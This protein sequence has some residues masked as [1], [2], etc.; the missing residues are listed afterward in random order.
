MRANCSAPIIPAVSGVTIGVHRHHV[1]LGEQV[2]ERVR[3]LV[4]VGVVRDHAHAE[5]LEP[6]A[7]SARPTAP[8]PDDARR[9]ARR[10]ATPGSAGRGWCRR[11]RSVPRARRRRRRA[12]PRFTAN[13]S[14]TVISATASALR[15]GARSTGMPLLGGGGRR[16]RWW[17]RPGTSRWRR[18]GRSSTGPFTESDST[19]RRSAPS[20]SMRAARSSALYMRSGCWSIHGSSTTSAS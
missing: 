15:P 13:R 17:G 20:A 8:R 4:V 19:T 10:A 1:G 14:A 7:S 16:R 18:S 5:A 2:V 12:S 3:G 9:C 11:G 6:P